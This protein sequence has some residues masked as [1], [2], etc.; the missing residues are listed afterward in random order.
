MAS[1]DQ[2]KVFVSYSHRDAKWLRRLQVH[3]KPLEQEDIIDLWADT[4][5]PP[6]AVWQDKIQEAL[7]T[8][9]V[10]LVLV[11]ADFLA[12]DFIKKHELP[13]RDY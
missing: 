9:N 5:I 2:R 4:K 1:S 10:A 7:D 13:I 3:L 8:A 12:S 11:S 6:G